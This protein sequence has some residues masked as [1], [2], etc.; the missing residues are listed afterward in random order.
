MARRMLARGLAPDGMVASPALRARSTAHLLARGIGFPEERIAE[1]E[2]IY[3]ATAGRLLTVVR[4][5]DPGCRHVVLVGHHPGLADLCTLLT[6]TPPDHFPTL[7]TAHLLIH[8]EEWRQVER[9][10][11]DLVWFDYPKKPRP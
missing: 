5:L 8:E 9:G 11:A 1:D 4:E 3:E 7:G 10:S 2:R 6:G